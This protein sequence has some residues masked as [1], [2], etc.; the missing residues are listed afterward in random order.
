MGRGLLTREEINILRKS[1]YISGVNE[2]Q[3]SYTNEFK[4]HFMEEYFIGKKPKQIFEDA[5]LDPE[6]L[7]SKRIERAAQRWK[8]S[9]AAGSLGAYKDRRN[10]EDDTSEHGEDL[11]VKGYLN[12]IQKQKEEI[13]ELRAE[14]R[15]LKSAKRRKEKKSKVNCQIAAD[16]LD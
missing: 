7:G 9:Y 2:K 13:K 4:Y 11:P 6:I 12:V 10:K 3:I 5:G 1:P 14:V 8:E 15:R 16:D